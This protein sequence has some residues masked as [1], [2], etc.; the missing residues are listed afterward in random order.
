MCWPLTGSTKVSRYGPWRSLR[1]GATCNIG[2]LAIIPYLGRALITASR[3]SVRYAY[4][5]RRNGAVYIVS[6]ANLLFCSGSVHI[7]ILRH[8]VYIEF[9]AFHISAKFS[10]ICCISSYLHAPRVGS[11]RSSI[12]TRSWACPAW[13]YTCISI[14][15][16]QWNY[17]S[18]RVRPSSR[19]AACAAWRYCSRYRV[20]IRCKISSLSD[21]VVYRNGLWSACSGIAS[22]PWAWPVDKMIVC[23]RSFGYC[24][25]R[26]WW[27]C[28]WSW[29]NTSFRRRT[30]RF[31]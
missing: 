15:C 12:R 4:V 20:S 10:S 11:R 5:I 28:A 21:I 23:S 16:S 31:S 17:R 9:Q 19:D 8:S 3:L 6:S 18:V 7:W 27:I 26:S 1:I 13:E 22:A 14:T 25:C 2:H 24:N 29:S 30:C